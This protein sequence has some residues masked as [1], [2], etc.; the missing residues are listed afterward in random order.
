ML[1]AVPSGLRSR[2]LEVAT[3]LF[4][5]SVASFVTFPTPFVPH[6]RVKI[7]SHDHDSGN[8]TAEAADV[9]LDNDL[10]SGGR[11]IRRSRLGP[12]C[13]EIHPQARQRIVTVCNPVTPQLYR[14]MSPRASF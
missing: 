13:A 9:V 4:G 7:E 11:S 14:N 3:V 10:C 1:H 2:I 5:M 6:C 12:C 8:S